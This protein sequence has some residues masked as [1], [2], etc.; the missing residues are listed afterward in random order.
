MKSR[1]NSK[2][3][4]ERGECC[5]CNKSLPLRDLFPAAM[6]RDSVVETIK[7]KYP[8]WNGEGY[9]CESDLARI[10][11]EHVQRIIEREI[12]EVTDLEASV[13]ESLREHEV[14]SDDVTEPPASLGARLADLVAKA[15]GSWGFI[16]FFLGFIAAWILLNSIALWQ[17][18]FD[19]HPYILLNLL[20]SCIAAIQAPIIMMS[21][22]RQEEKDRERARNDY[23]VN[24]KA[25]LE[26]RHLH[27]KIDH[28]LV[29][30][31]KRLVD[32]QQ[33]Q[34]A[35]LETL[36]GRDRPQ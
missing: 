24:L 25:E 20:L 32:I 8:E 3:I 2:R 34:I 11:G 6:I 16:I 7:L 10:R 18:P 36:A 21:Q 14:I 28:L 22:N 15:G 13:I 17:Q 33:Q 12:G 9:V 19:P 30:Q 27:E 5:I 26:I 23:Q 4:R 1:K 31:W 29:E 35:I